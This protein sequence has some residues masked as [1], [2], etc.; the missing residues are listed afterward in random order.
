MSSVSRMTGPHGDISRVTVYLGLLGSPCLRCLADK[1]AWGY[2]GPATGHRARMPGLR[3]PR[4][5][6]AALAG[7]QRPLAGVESQRR[8]PTPLV[9]TVKTGKTETGEERRGHSELPGPEPP[10]FHPKTW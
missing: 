8:E 10:H 1:R 9:T 4:I 5:L 3:P 2:L 6:T 7:G